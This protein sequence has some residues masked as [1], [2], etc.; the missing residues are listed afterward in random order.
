MKIENNRIQFKFRT[1]PEVL[2]KLKLSPSKKRG[3]SAKK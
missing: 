3:R 2:D 1:E